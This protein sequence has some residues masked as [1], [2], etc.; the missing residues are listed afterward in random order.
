VQQ[1]EGPCFAVLGFDFLA[2][3]VGGLFGSCVGFE[4][5]DPNGTGDQV[6][7]FYNPSTNTIWY[8]VWQQFTNTMRA[9]NGAITITYSAC[10]LQTRSN[11][12]TFVWERDPAVA[13]QVVPGPGTCE[14]G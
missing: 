12:E 14:V 5:P 4:H 9:T 7:F 8:L 10:G 1:V 6:Q 11:S 2:R 3:A 13:R